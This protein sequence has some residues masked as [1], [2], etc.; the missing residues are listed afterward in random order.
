MGNQKYAGDAAANR[1]RYAIEVVFEKGSV[2]ID[3]SDGSSL[4]GDFRK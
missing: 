1:S 2:Y 3:A 4:G